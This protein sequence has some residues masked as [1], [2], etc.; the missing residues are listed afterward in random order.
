M[1]PHLS[2]LLSKYFL[3]SW[4]DYILNIPFSHSKTVDP[5][6]SNFNSETYSNILYFIVQKDASKI[7]ELDGTIKC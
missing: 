6:S 7:L 2:F 4:V 1:L 3:S 5:R